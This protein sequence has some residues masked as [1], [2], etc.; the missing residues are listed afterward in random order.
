[1][2]PWEH[3]AVGYLLYSLAL[4]ALARRPPTGTGLVAILLGTQLPDLVDKPLSWGLGWFPSGF[5]VAHSVFLAVPLGLAA[6]GLSARTRRWR[7]AAAFVVGYWSHLVADVLSPLRAGGPPLLSRVLWPIADVTPYETD[8]GL[9]RGLVYL[10][11]F[12]AT[13]DP[14]SLLVSGLLVGVTL[15]VWALDGAPGLAPVA[16]RIDSLWPR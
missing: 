4:R 3:A 2:W 10:Q 5:A 13:I 12:L 7:V 1:M 14:V 9:G 16:R 15:A 8:Y 6:L 11:E